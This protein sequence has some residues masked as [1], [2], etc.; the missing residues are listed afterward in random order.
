MTSRQAIHNSVW[1]QNTPL[2]QRFEKLRSTHRSDVAIVGGGITGLSTAL[3]LIERGFSVAVYEAYVIGAGTTAGS[4]GHLDAYPEM[5]ITHLVSSLGMEKASKYLS[6]QMN[7][8]DL[9]EKRADENC[10]VRRIP[11]FYY[12][13]NSKDEPFMRREFEAALSAGLPVTWPSEFPFRHAA[14][15][16]RVDRMGRINISAYLRNLASQVVANGGTIFENSPV[17][18]VTDDQP[19]HLKAGDGTA[20][21]SQLVCCVHCNFTDA[22]LIDLQITAYQ[23]YALVALVADSFPDVL[24]W[25]NADPY[26]YT[27]RLN[28]QDDHRIVV[29]G[30]DHRTGAGDPS[31]SIADLEKYVRERFQVE[32]IES[33]WSAEFFYPT[34]GLP[35]IGQA[36]GKKNVWIATGLS[37][38]GLTTGTMAGQLLAKQIASEYADFETELSPSRFSLS[39][40]GTVISEQSTAVVDYAERVLPAKSIVPAALSAGEGAV[41]NVNGVHAAVCRDAAGNIHQRSPICTHMGGIVRWNDF[42]HT[43][44]CPVH[45]GRYAACGQRLYGPPP[46]DLEVLAKDKDAT[47]Q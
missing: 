20:E 27:R 35:L 22:I 1:I 33:P 15:G 21:F 5:E 30:C 10:D 2:V 24:L 44:D 32:K 38:V 39:H 8:I 7:A 13:E 18:F 9:I 46:A 26:F 4:T 25:D 11:A 3:E 43:W 19:R 37:G 34:D 16:L 6:L 42:E 45:G 17:E 28:S 47:D 14:T 36:P 31:Q 40:L 23:S 12:S 41:G 29:G